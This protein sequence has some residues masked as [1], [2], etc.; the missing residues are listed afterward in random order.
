ME[1]DENDQDY[2]EKK[3]KTTIDAKNV[4]EK[5]LRLFA[6]IFSFSFG[7]KRSDHTSVQSMINLSWYLHHV[8]MLIYFLLNIVITGFCFWI[9]LNIFSYRWNHAYFSKFSVIADSSKNNTRPKMTFNL[10][11]ILEK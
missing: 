1:V 8:S 4:E 9:I 6:C 5:G 2:Y 11:G 10:K 7:V 3:T